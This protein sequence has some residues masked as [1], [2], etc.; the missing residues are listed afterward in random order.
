[1]KTVQNAKRIV[2]KVGTSTLTHSNGKPDFRRFEAIAQT[3]S[4]IH[5]AGLEVVLVSSAAISVG[6]SKLGIDERPSTI[7][8][9]QAV[10][11]VGQSEL[12]R[13]Y[14][15]FFSMFGHKVAQIL[16]TRDELDRPQVRRNAESTFD[17]L[18]EMGVIPIVN[19][20]DTLSYDEIEFGDND[21]LSAHVAILCRAD[22]VILLSDIDGFYDSDPHDNPDA[23]LIPVVR[24]INDDIRKCAGGAGTRRGTGGLVTKIHAAEISCGA[25][26]PL[27]LINGDKPQSIYD[28]RD[29]KSVGTV[30]CAKED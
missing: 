19:E 20:N 2:V 17:T 30:F 16:L 5:N 4:D 21:T 3:L 24:E 18:I 1:M 26:I 14:E 10:S 7:S 11:A 15:H 12:M 6:C 29:G 9:K 13:I 28:L 25:G 23:K 22:A 27:Y 8:G